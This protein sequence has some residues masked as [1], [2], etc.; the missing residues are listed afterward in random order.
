MN[1][2]LTALAFES[3]PD[4]EKIRGE[5]A[6]LRERIRRSADSHNDDLKRCD[7]GSQAIELLVQAL[8]LTG[9]A[10]SAEPVEHD[11]LAAIRQLRQMGTLSTR[12]A[13]ALCD[14]YGLYRQ[15]DWALRLLRNRAPEPLR[16]DP[17]EL[18][19]VQ[20]MIEMPPDTE[21][22]TLSERIEHSKG[23]VHEI[24]RQ[25]LEGRIGSA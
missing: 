24:L 2:E 5:L 25:F 16:I 7:G 22:M 19:F 11:D 3:R 10:D 23:T 6:A 1:R 8:Q 15:V 4:A 17:K 14:A 9:P 13:D 12:H 21:T 18:P 20:R